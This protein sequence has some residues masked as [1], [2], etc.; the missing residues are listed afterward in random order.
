MEYEIKHEGLRARRV[1]H[2]HKYIREDGMLVHKYKSKKGYRITAG[3]QKQGKY[4][5]GFVDGKSV[6]MH[7]LVATAFLPNPT[8]LPVVDHI[9]EDKK[10]NRISNLRWCTAAE[11]TAFYHNLPARAEKREFMQSTQANYDKLESTIAEMSK[12]IDVLQYEKQELVKEVAELKAFKLASY[13]DFELYKETELA[14]I[15]TLNT[16]YK[17]YR[18][19]SGKKYANVEAMIKAT[20]KQVVV[21]GKDFESAGSAA[22]YIVAAEDKLG[23]DRKRSTVSKEIRRYLQGKREQWVMY[24]LYTIGY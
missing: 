21:D 13:T 5:H 12:S 10:D 2:T 14:K 9:N 1:G 17:G 8:N 22:A 19:I 15:Q 16:N 3:C 24:E 23:N 20:G 18:D 11:N 6:S 7:R 4:L